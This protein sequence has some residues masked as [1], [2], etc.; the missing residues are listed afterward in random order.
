[1][2]GFKSFARQ[3]ELLFGEQFNVILGPNGSGKS[4]VL[5]SLCFV[6]GRLSSKALRAEKTANLIYNGGKL[7]K[8]MKQGEVSIYFDNS[9]GTFPTEEKEIKVTRV[10]KSDGSSVYKINDKKRTRQQILELLSVARIDPEGF[11]I[12]LQGD[13]VRF[14]EMH[15]EERRKLIEEISGIAVY[16]D[17]KQKALRELEKVEEKF[18]E[19]DIVLTERKTHLNQLKKDHDQAIKFR[20][21]EGKVKENKAS[22]I[23]LQIQAKEKRQN[24]LNQRISERQQ[25]LDKLNEKVSGIKKEIEE[26]RQEKEKINKE[27]EEKSERERVSLHKEIEELK[28]RLAE[29]S[30]RIENF[31]KQIDSIALREQ[32]LKKELEDYDLQIGELNEQKQELEN[33]RKSKLKEQAVIDAKIEQFRKKHELDAVADVEKELE[34]LDQ[35]IEEKQ[36]K[37]QE[38]QEH[39]QELMR[40]KDQLEFQIN[41]IDDQ[42]KKVLKIEEE[43]QQ[44]IEELKV[45]KQKFKESILELNKKLNLD[46]TFARQLADLKNKLSAAEESHAKLRARGITIKES[47]EGNLAVNKLLDLK[48][49]NKIK[50]IYGTVAE[51]GSV[52]AKYAQALETTAGP[53]IN[54]LIVESDRTAAECIKFLKQNKLGTATFIPLNKIK[55]KDVSSEIKK[56]EKA[57]GAHGLAIDLIS[58]DRKYKKAFSYVFGS[59]L[60]VD[61]IDAARRIGIGRV[62]MTTLDGDLCEFSGAMQGGY[63]R[64]KKSGHFQHKELAK[65]ISEQKDVVDSFKSQIMDVEKARIANEDLISKL[66]KERADLEGEI[67]KLE[68]SLHLESSDLDASKQKKQDLKKRLND[69]DKELEELQS[70]LLSLNKAI[71]ESKTKK[72]LLRT[73]ITELRSPTLLA[74]LNT[75]EEKKT[76]LKDETLKVETEIASILTRTKDFILPE[77]EKINEIIKQQAKEKDSFSQQIKELS[78]KVKAGKSVLQD[79]ENSAKKFYERYRNLFSRRDKID[80]DIEKQESKID[81]LREQ[82]KEIEIG[83][84]EVNLKKAEAVAHLSGLQQEFQQYEGVKINTQK[85]EEDLKKD[86]EKFEKM[87][88]EIGNVNM[89]ALEIY[90]D[91]ERE[92]NKLLEKKEKLIS[93]KDEVIA[94]MAEIEGKKKELFMRTFDVINNNFKQI[95]SALSRKGDA[96]LVL[97]NPENPFEGGLSIKVRL[98]G[99]KF[100]DIRSLSGGEKTL[101]ALAFIFSIQEHEPHSFY[102]LDEVDA[103][104]DKHNS[105]KLGKL[106]RKYADK[107]QYIMISHNDAIISEGDNL[108]GVSMDKDGISKVVSLKL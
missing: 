80:E 18:K 88:I 104:L 5:D 34:Q 21:L 39:K 1:M 96:S 41:N 57:N 22:Y 9:K 32:Q 103:A 90:E 92:Y 36:K 38:L 87:V 52:D 54:S 29:D 82:S 105:E 42:I 30:T 3:T 84:N 69:F 53:R 48:A 89:R 45:K 93:E 26:G 74:E 2:H 19:A 75:Y 91:V 97:E 7:K 56:L 60:V 8:P 94:M 77:K 67:I 47:M 106:I 85:P 17:K 95:F 6:L 49:K 4:N 64:L 51:L 100:L 44:Q 27:L 107:A 63:R 58:F 108:Y 101:T 55:A 66:R 33:Q 40:E 83:M 11:N 31:R 81:E 62:R 76:Q 59:T 73:K 12:I 46:S 13:I 28:V 23:Y 61:D 43:H 15:P 70:Q 71:A 72:Q 79:K 37:A 86:I 65:E 20:E 24:S 99:A 16:E 78:E 35:Q 102:V 98:T 68:K 10:I 50:G 14:T 25:K